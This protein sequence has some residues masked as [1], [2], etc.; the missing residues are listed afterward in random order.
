MHHEQKPDEACTIY[1]LLS[2]F[3]VDVHS[4]L[5][6]TFKDTRSIQSYSA[7]GQTMPSESCLATPGWP[8]RRARPT[9]SV[10]QPA[11]DGAADCDWAEL[12]RDLAHDRDGVGA[13]SLWRER[14]GRYL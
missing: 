6:L 9:L 14:R 8:E 12:A 2:L 1:L 4:L 7:F 13:L 5:A 11:G 10:S 3:T